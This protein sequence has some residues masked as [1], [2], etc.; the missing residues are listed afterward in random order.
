LIRIAFVI[1]TLDQSGAERQLTLLA[2]GLPRDQYE[3]HV[4]A[5][6]RG[7][8][9]ATV[10]KDQDV[11]VHVL[12][13]RFRFDPLTWWRLRSLLHRLQPQ[14]VQS[15]IF[16][17]NSYVRLPGVCP[18]NAKVIVSER[19][20]DVWKSDWQKS[21]DRKLGD[22]MHMMTANSDSVAEFY[23]NEIGIPDERLSV[24]PNGIPQT[25]L[26]AAGQLHQELG[27]APDCR[28]IGFVGRLAPQKNL[29]DL[30]WGFHLLKQAAPSPVALVMI[31][32]GP[33]R[34]SLAQ[35]LTDLGT[36]DL[37]HFLGHRDDASQL[38]QD[39]SVFC[40]PSGFEGMS[41]SLMEAM[42]CGVP[43][44]V[45]D[46]PPNLELIR[47]EQNG[48]TFPV[49]KAPDLAKAILRL[50]RDEELSRKLGKAAQ[51]VIAAQHSVAAL[52]QRHE[53]LYQRLLSTADTASE[54]KPVEQK[55]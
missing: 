9:Y 1:P 33:Q 22:R 3:P 26:S 25:D 48:L 51:D 32:E 7:G 18:S 40:L 45:S 20:V 4:I 43:S 14:V 31:G 49:G 10:L 28:I 23:R 8:H 41:N 37:V 47:H 50:L 24:I 17:A 35:F 55:G 36:R 39:F 27:L 2:G 38:L 11:P 5:L 13:K 21:L 19:C 54:L 12:G 46:I 44:V 29:R 52:V 30:V 42:A 34:D 16:A 15:F 53:E 6:N